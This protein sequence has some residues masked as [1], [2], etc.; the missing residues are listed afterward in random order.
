LI[1]DPQSPPDEEPAATDP[2][3]ESEPREDEA[4]AV[5]TTVGTGS[6]IAVT[7]TV[8]MLLITVLILGILFL[9]RWL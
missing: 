7:C 4:P 5:S 9:M 2:P 1:D 8:L 6:Y 3:A